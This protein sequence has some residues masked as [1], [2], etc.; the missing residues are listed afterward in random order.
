MTTKT[1][2]APAI[3]VACA[4]ALTS[5]VGSLQLAISGQ[6]KPQSGGAMSMEDM[7]KECR[8]HCEATTNSIDQTM[9]MMEEARQSND[10]AKMRAA[11]DSA[12]KPLAEMKDHMAMCMQMMD[13][14]R[15]THGCADPSKKCMNPGSKKSGKP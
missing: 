13:R 3:G 1:R 7:M 11:L 10:P 15:Q 14:M 9:R 2:L 5:I 12:Q 4:L 6:Q 8:K